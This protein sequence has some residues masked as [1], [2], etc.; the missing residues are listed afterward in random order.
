MRTLRQWHW[1][2]SAVCLI[3]MLL[4]T[5][6][7]LTLNHASRIEA[8]PT[9]T[10]LTL[11]LPPALT[12]ELSI[13]DD[14]KAPLPAAVSAWLEQR[15]PTSIGRRPGEWSEGEFYLSM[16]GPGSDAWLSIDLETGFI[17]Y[18][19]TERGWVSHFNDLHKGRNTGPAWQWFI[20]IFAV[21][22][23]V[24]CIT[25]LLLLQ[26]HAG[27]RWITWPLLGLGLIVPL[28]IALIFIH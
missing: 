2:S 9:V 27:Q 14:D 6:T 10:H 8:K 16:P 12:D 25:G 18:E 1:I 5:V 23:L 4:F 11:Q 26:M 13:P 3:G 19:R 28:L 17:E 24:S 20:D 15:L 21:A 7:G 22:C